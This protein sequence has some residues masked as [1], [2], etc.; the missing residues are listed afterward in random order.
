METS[1][2]QSVSK[3]NRGFTLIELLVVIAIIALLAAILFPVFARAR[4]NAR[5]SSCLSNMKQIGLGVHQYTQDYDERMPPYSADDGG[6]S[7]TTTTAQKAA[8]GWAVQLQPYLSSIQI[9][10]CPSES[11]K[12]ATTPNQ[13]FS[14]YAYNAEISGGAVNNLAFTTPLSAFTYTTSTA[15]IW[16]G[17]VDGIANSWGTS[18]NLDRAQNWTLY[19]LQADD[20]N[21]STSYK[22]HYYASRRHLDGMNITF[23]D[24]HAKWL[25]PEKVTAGATPTASNYT[26]MIK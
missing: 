17:A 26:L 12:G 8:A 22:A 5:R 19:Y 14:D 6:A 20:S 9:L 23:V 15:M 16:D 24:G 1:E 11:H 2:R 7:N 4:E 25:V 3:L 13:N 21:P 18:I 10:Q